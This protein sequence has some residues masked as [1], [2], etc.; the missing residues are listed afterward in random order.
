MPVG[1]WSYSAEHSL[2]QERRY[3][4]AGPNQPVMNLADII[5]WTDEKCQPSESNPSQSARDAQEVNNRSGSN[6]NVTLIVIIVLIALTIVAA[7]IT[8]LLV[9]ICKP[10]KKKK[11]ERDNGLVAERNELVNHPINNFASTPSY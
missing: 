10:K 4:T 8:T 3:P 6:G 7:V 1:G 11:N 9:C 2:R 5:G